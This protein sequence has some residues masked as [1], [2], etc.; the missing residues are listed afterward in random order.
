M[1]GRPTTAERLRYIGRHGIQIRLGNPSKKVGSGKV[2]FPTDRGHARMVWYRG[3][4]QFDLLSILM[5][6]RTVREIDVEAPEIRWTDGLAWY[7][8]RPSLVVHREG[9]SRTIYE[10][11]W[12]ANVEAFAVERLAAA[13]TPFATEHGYASVEIETDET[14]RKA[15][16]LYNADLMTTAAAAPLDLAAREAVLVRAHSRR[17]QPKTMAELVHGI[18]DG[19]EALRLVARLLFDGDLQLLDPTARIGPRAIL[20]AGP[21]TNGSMT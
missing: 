21:T 19:C 8:Y 1:S 13:I 11:Q 17:R 6:D 10:T 7:R 9:G 14:L 3:E 12:Q 15:P 5:S 18:A 20:S 2:P 16:R 4:L